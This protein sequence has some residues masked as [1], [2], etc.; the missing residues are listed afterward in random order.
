VIYAGA[1]YVLAGTGYLKLNEVYSPDV[2]NTV[3][4]EGVNYLARF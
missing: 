4:V 3:Y 1:T 2:H